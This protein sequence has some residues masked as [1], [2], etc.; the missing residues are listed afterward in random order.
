M[1]VRL[2]RSLEHTAKRAR[3]PPRLSRLTPSYRI[4]VRQPNGGSLDLARS[5]ANLPLNLHEKFFVPME[6]NLKIR[7]AQ[8][9]DAERLIEFNCAIARET[10]DRELEPAIVRRGV[11]RGLVH[12]GEVR[13]YVAELERV[14]GCPEVVGCLMFTREWSD[15]RDGWLMWVQSVYVVAEYRGRGVFRRMLDAASE[16]VRQLPDVVGMRLYVER[17]NEAAQAVY[18][19]TGFVDSGYKVLEKLF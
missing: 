1:S 14:V 13:Y 10:E 6:D 17:E 16:E 5:R 19:R 3:S 11:L 7:R 8:M 18:F 12:A 15:W 9:D 4:K 2:H